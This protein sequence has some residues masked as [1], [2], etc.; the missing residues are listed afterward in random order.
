MHLISEDIYIDIKFTSWTSGGA[1]GGFSYERATADPT[2]SIWTASTD[3]QWGEAT[4]WNPNGIPGVGT[5]VTFGQQGSANPAV[6]LGGVDRAVGLI[7]F[8]ATTGTTIQNGS[9]TFDRGGLRSKICVEGNTHS[10]AVPVSLNNDLLVYGAGTLT[11][12]GDISGTGKNLTM[13]GPG[14]LTLSGANTY[15]G[16]TTVDGGT[17]QFTKQVSLYNNNSASWT[18]ANIKVESGGTAAFNVG[19]TDEFTAGDVTTLLTN[20][21][22][23]VSNNGLKAGSAIGFDTTNASGGTFTIANVIQDTTG[24]G[25]GAVGLT[26]TGSGTL[27][28]SAANTHSGTTTLSAG[29][30][31]LSNANAVQNSTLTMSGGGLVFDS[32]VISNAFNFGGLAASASG[33]GYDIDLQNNAGSPAPVALTVG[34]NNADTAYA[35]VL[36]GSGSLTKTGTGTLTLSGANTY[37]GTTTLNGGSLNLGVAEDANV[38]GPLG[39]QWANAAE[40]IILSGGYLQYSSVNQNDY[41]GRFSTANNQAYNVDTNGQDVT[42]ATPLTSGDGSLNK[43]GSGTLTLADANT[44]TGT[45]T[46]SGGNLNL[47]VAENENVSGPLGTQSATAAGTIILSGGYLQYSNVNQNDYS[48]RFSTADNQA[49]NVD[50]NEQNVTWATALTSS[51]GSLTKTGLGTLTLSGNSNYSGDTTVNGGTLEINAGTVASLKIPTGGTAILNAPATATAASVSGGDLGLYSSVSGA[52]LVTGGTVTV[53]PGAS[54]G[55]ANFSAGSVYATNPLTVTNVAKLGEVTVSGGGASFTLGGW[56]VVNPTPGSHRTIT[57]SGDTL[58]IFIPG[59]GTDGSIGGSFPVSSSFNPAT[60][61]WTVSGNPGGVGQTSDVSAWH[62]TEMPAG[63]FDVKIRV[64]GGLGY[65]RR[66]GLMVRDGLDNA[67]ATNMAAVWASDNTCYLTRVDGTS[68]YQ[69]SVGGGKNWMRLTKSGSTV[70][71]FYGTDGVSFTEYFSKTYT[72]WG[73]ATGKTY[74][75]LDV[76]YGN[77]TATFDN[78]TFFGE[79]VMPDWSTTDIAATATSTLSLPAGQITLGNLSLIGA[80]T[81]VTLSGASSVSFENIAGGGTVTNGTSADIPLT[82]RNGS[83]DFSGAINDGSTNKISLVKDGPDTLTL[84]GAN[85]YSGSTTINNGTLQIGATGSINNTPDIMVNSTGTLDVSPLAGPFTL[86]SGKKI[87]VN[88]KVMGN[89]AIDNGALL[90]GTGGSLVGSTTGQ[91]VTINGTISPGTYDAGPATDG[92]GTLAVGDSTYDMDL[93]LGATSVYNWGLSPTGWGYI[94]VTGAVTVDSGAT[95]RLNNGGRDPTGWAFEILRWTSDTPPERVPGVSYAPAPSGTEVHWIGAGS[96]PT[97]NWDTGTNWDLGAYQGGNIDIIGKMFVL[98]GVTLVNIAP[99][100]TSA[101]V[102]APTSGVDVTGP[103]ANTTVQSLEIGN[104]GGTSASS[105]TLV[106]GVEFSVTAATTV[107]PSAA[108]TVVGGATLTSASVAT[109]GDTTFAGG[110]V[111][112]VNTLSVNNGGI[113]RVAEG[114]QLGSSGVT[115]GGGTLQLTGSAFNGSRAVTVNGGA[116]DVPVTATLAG[117]IGGSAPLTKTGDGTLIITGTGNTFP[118]AAVNAGTLQGNA[119]SIKTNVALNAAGANVTFDQPSNG[120][121]GK[122]VSGDGGL[123]KA[124]AGT[125]T[126]SNSQGYLGSTIISGGTLKLQ[127]AQTSPPVEDYARWFDATSLGLADGA[128]VTQWND[129]S[130]NAAHATVPGGNQNP[131]YIADAGTGTGLGAVHFNAGGGAGDSEALIFARDS[132]IRTVF[133]IFKGNS[134]LLTD[135]NEYHFHRNTDDNPATPLWCGYTSDRIRNGQTYVNGSLVDGTSYAMP[136]DSYN[137]YN[138]VEVLTNGDPVQADSFNKDRVF[139]AGNQSQAEVIIYDRVLTDEERLQVEAY[140]NVK[141]FGIGGGGSAADLLPIATALSITGGS[142]LDLN[143]VTQQVASLSDYSGSGGTVT[144]NGK[145]DV[146]LTIGGTDTTN[147]SGVI[148]DGAT[149]KIALTKSGSGMQILSGP[150]TYT[151]P[152]IVN[153]GTLQVASSIK[154]DNNI[155][156]GADCTLATSATVRSTNVTAALN[157]EGGSTPTGT[158][159]LNDGLLAINYTGDSP[160]DTVRAQI[161]S[162]YNAAV[163]GDWSGPGI[164]SALLAGGS[165][166]NSIGYAYNGESAVWFDSGIPFGD[167]T[168]VAANAVLVRYTLIGDVNL[169]GIVDD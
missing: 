98:S 11:M 151:G 159:D 33:A 80:G 158:L 94:N 162:A 95:V 110:A 122:V 81:Q 51:G 83:G 87:T 32:S 119:A 141:W 135:A 38:S 10:I 102:I 90:I 8:A 62:Y 49:Y 77:I 136:T 86:G 143:G 74:L 96:P 53:G 112:N 43:T 101:V 47:G 134:F 73:D 9:L 85:G 165:T 125:L 25:G 126:L 70:Q 116:I 89:L 66:A 35:G 52:L 46:L 12:S 67:S 14:T 155:D 44:Y 4:N 128:A 156:I 5:N 1:G 157:I 123:T 19:G 71:G 105:L 23:D 138:L 113:L 168:V 109:D 129:G 108:L 63:D 7:T 97:Q 145:S 150:N 40:T 106:T 142:T 42:W 93:H 60:G 24:T 50:T 164:T 149:N 65:W 100:P 163:G 79:G 34:G 166:T 146:T 140:L 130:T 121:Y 127:G 75:G 72:T 31:N 61:V 2:P 154:N 56:D 115:L 169:D 59:P 104:A 132:D 64:T 57:A 131:T 88:G 6:E 36:S 148:S 3:T 78:V 137:G 144:N 99:L 17:L 114:G 124:G 118:S 45:T 37:T 58:T 84:S 41:S 68:E 117:P 29:T 69:E 39:T 15:T 103:S 152:T 54:V 160:I 20:L 133:S 107:H 147:F 18:A 76:W 161:V 27:T 26:K 139:H 167:A 22:S 111:V 21:D 120:T 28:L 92:I 153:G 48:G 91:S 82:L 55:A 16:T 30:V 13:F